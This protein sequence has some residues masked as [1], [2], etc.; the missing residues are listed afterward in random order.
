M[1]DDTVYLKHIKE[2]IHRVQENIAGGRDRFMASH[3]LQDAVLRNLQTMTE[4]TQRL[5]E[6]LKAT[7][8]EIEWARIVAF[9]NVLVHNYLG[10]DMERIWDVV[11]RDIPVLKQAVL[12][13]LEDI[14]E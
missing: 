9:R 13:M 5:S 14:V 11:Q 3:T 2:C 4:A 7:H 10:V 12:S 8:P 6:G 1:K